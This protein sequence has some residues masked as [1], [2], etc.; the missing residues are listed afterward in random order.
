MAKM[1]LVKTTAFVLLGLRSATL[2]VSVSWAGDVKTGMQPLLQIPPTLN[3]AEICQLPSQPLPLAIDW[4][5]WD[6]KTPRVAVD[7]MLLDAK[8]LIDGGND[9]YR[10]APL[11][12]R[13]LEYL[14]T[15]TT[16]STPDAKR[17][18]ALL[19]LDPAAGPTD[20]ARATVLLREATSAQL[21]SAALTMGKLLRSGALPNSSIADA[22]R[23]LSFA[24]GLGDPVAALELASAYNAA[25]AVVPFPDAPQHFAM[26]AAINVQTT[27]VSGNCRIATDV[28]EYWL[29][30]SAENRVALAV[31]W[32]KIG[33]I[34][35]DSRAMAHLADLYENAMDGKHDLAKARDY[36][37]AAVAAGLVRAMAPAARLR[38][39]DG[40]EPEK[41]LKLLQ[42]GMANGDPNAYV[43]AARYFRGDYSGKAD[44]ANMLDVLKQGVEEVDV[45]P[46]AIEILANAYL[47]GQGTTPDPETA[48]KLYRRLLTTR[49]ADAEALYA[50][51]LLKNH[52]DL[53][54]AREHVLA[55]GAKGSAS[56]KFYIAEIAACVPKA[57][58]DALALLKDAA[59]AGSTEAIR[60]LARLAEDN[61]DH[62][63]AVIYLQKAI[64][65]DDRVA[66]IELART[67]VAMG[68][69]SGDTVSKLLRQATAPGQDLVEGKF[70]LAQAYM[71]GEFGG[72]VHMG[73]ELLASLADSADP[74][75]DVAIINRKLAA[76][77][78]TSSAQTEIGMRLHRAAKGGSAEGMLLLSHYLQNRP[79]AGETAE[80]WLIRAAQAGNADA[81]SQ[82]PT[83]AALATRV[84]KTLKEGITC[85][86][87]TL[88]QEARLY[89]RSGD[90]AGADAVL[91]QAE[92]IAGQRPR[93]LHA[94]AQAY[95]SDA[96][97]APKDYASAITLY[98]RSGRAGY[99]KSMLALADLYAGPKL[100]GKPAE[101]IIWYRDAAQTGD[102]S[103]VRALTRYSLQAPT[104]ESSKLA[105][106]ALQAVANQGV[107]PAMQ[108]YGVLLASM[109][110]DR[111]EDGITFLKKAADKGDVQ[112]MKSLARIYAAS[113]DGSV[114][115][116][117]STHWTRMAAEKGDPEAMFQYAMALDLGF[118]VSVDRQSAKSWQQKAKQNGFV[119]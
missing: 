47:T 78:I 26:L 105:L 21:T 114:S 59:D 31:E 23:Y 111:R 62:T 7:R 17:Q 80:D 46:Y 8:R 69:N 83:D 85:S 25:G 108:A 94:L 5:S 81:L 103:A 40:S 33:A 22:E 96:P 16:Q 63:S 13:M 37:D 52:L 77:E 27:L 98:E 54:S 116:D 88:V 65:L 11:A 87:P 30:S 107:T 110:D 24:T 45:S 9:V 112:S 51:Y 119:R 109:G 36:W 64:D 67:L 75:V 70:T 90:A 101:A 49:T 14:A 6:G 38:L 97:D 79:A 104:T 106:D 39:V 34:S 84:L 20:P 32:F 19:L 58:G 95:E 44:F 29:D 72:D 113:M 73:D 102:P 50:R 4:K 82:L 76:G 57:P 68:G 55:A 10:D 71:N 1:I 115:A 48:D 91:E 28:G 74:D 100:G 18:L 56:A 86:I 60:R 53:Q 15:G 93:D 99:L 12:R 3:Y 66:M 118:G 89:R 61:G 117:E 2:L 41:G 92:R 42:T 35:A 43:I